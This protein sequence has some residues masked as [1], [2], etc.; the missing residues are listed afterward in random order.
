MKMNTKTLL[1][2]SLFAGAAALRADDGAT[3]VAITGNDS[4]K[5][6]LN[7]FTVHP[8]QLVRVEFTNQ[9]SLPKDVMGHN[10]VLLKLGKDSAAYA[11]AAVQAKAE[12]YEPKALAGDVIA[13]VALLGPK[14]TGTVT[15]TAPTTP[16]DYVYLCSFPA[17]SQVGMHGIM[18]VR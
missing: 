2:L 3:P 12:G 16:G 13:S 8:G 10:W 6:S 17:H 11:A 4:M 14:Q 5:F 18:T 15:F 9:G 1:L 7:A